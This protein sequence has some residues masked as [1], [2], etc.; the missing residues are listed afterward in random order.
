VYK[1]RDKEGSRN[2]TNALNDHKMDLEML[3][4]LLTATRTDRTKTVAIQGK[5]LRKQEILLPS[6][7]DTQFY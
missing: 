6:Q 5:S 7:I 3:I 2:A 1:H 4:S